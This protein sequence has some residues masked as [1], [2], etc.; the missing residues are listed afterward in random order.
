[1]RGENEKIAKKIAA[2]IPYYIENKMIEKLIEDYKKVLPED[3]IYYSFL[4]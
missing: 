2:L 3:D 4:M 1:M